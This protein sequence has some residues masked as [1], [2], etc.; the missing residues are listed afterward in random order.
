[1][2]FYHLGNSLRNLFKNKVYSLFNIAGFSVGFTICIISGL[3]IYREYNI[4]KSYKDY[5]NIYRL[6]DDE[7]NMSVMQYDISGSLRNSIPEIKNI[8]PVLPVDNE[9]VIKNVEGDN[10]ITLP[11]AISTENDFFKIFQL[12]FL[13]GNPARPFTSDPAV[14]LT[15]SAAHKLFGRNDIVGEQIQIYGNVIPVT[16]VVEDMPENSSLKTEMFINSENGKMRFSGECK[17]GNEICYSTYPIF[18]SLNEGTDAKSLEEKINSNFPE[19]HRETNKIRLQPLAD[20]YL[21]QTVT[22]SKNLAGSRSLVLVFISLAA[23]ILILS[24]INYVNFALSQQLG[25]LKQLGIK[26]VNGA[27]I[28]QLRGSY[29]GEITF[30]V[31]ISFILAM[32]IC[33]GALPLFN[34]ILGVQLDLSNIL[35]PVFIV[36]IVSVLLIVILV[37]SLTPFYIISR[38]DIQML[39]GKKKTYFGKQWGKMFLTSC[40]MGITVVMFVCLFMLYKQLDYVKNHDLGFDQHHLIGIDFPDSNNFDAFRDDIDRYGFV[41][42][43]VYTSG[44]PGSVQGW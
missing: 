2:F 19:N 35:T 26:M 9:F 39:F 24:V 21:D 31:L 13:A 3:Y 7:K 4:D 17:G 36:S 42:S 8:T 11:N 43:M 32:L 16:A 15:R 5:Q 27:T 28:R 25:M 30:S 40:Q 6:V 1:M 12:D 44:A 33:M 22:D 29:V 38:F 41:Q 37:S 10:Y 34:Y 18:M 23:I 14:V 20:I